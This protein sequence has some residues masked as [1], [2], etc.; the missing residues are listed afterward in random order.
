MKVLL[1]HIVLD[2]DTTYDFS[3]HAESLAQAKDMISLMQNAVYD[4]ELEMPDSLM[5]ASET[6]H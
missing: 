6:L 5:W 2:D 3:L 1:F 4:G